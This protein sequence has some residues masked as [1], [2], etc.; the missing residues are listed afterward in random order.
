MTFIPVNLII[1][2][3][4]T[5]IFAGDLPVNDRPV[6]TRVAYF[7]KVVEKGATFG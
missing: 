4:L 7:L 1:N 5:N 3:H 2:P 6:Q